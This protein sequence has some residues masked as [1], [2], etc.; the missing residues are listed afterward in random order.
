MHTRRL[1]GNQS[2]SF[3]KRKRS[4]S[5]VFCGIFIISFFLIIFG[6]SKLTYL[7]STQISVI[8]VE[9]ASQDII[10][11]VRAAAEE[12]IKGDYLWMFSK[13]NSFLYPKDQIENKVLVASP[14]ID[15]VSVKRNKLDSI[16][17][18]VIEKKPAA[19][20]CVT[21]P[22]FV[23]GKLIF[24]EDEECA[25]IDE[26]GLIFKSAP[27]ISGTVYNRYYIPDFAGTAS[28]SQAYFG[29]LATSTKEFQN[30]QDLYDGLRKNNI[31]VQAI[32]FKD[33]G[34]YEAYVNN[35]HVQGSVDTGTAVIYFNN[36]RP[37]SVELDNL[38]LFWGRAMEDAKTHNK[39]PAFEY[40]DVRY[41]PNVFFRNIK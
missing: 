9:G 25:M 28:T 35:P 30:L 6:I 34:E 24:G 38:V 37:L 1:V 16:V 19:M 36:A 15:T 7:S 29:V 27:S 22:D 39:L 26:T 8:E 17:I 18:S 32:L 23:A 3:A 13:S 33:K 11:T 10:P 20:V 14:R 12:S 41:S 5:L 21:L 31:E 40:I 2:E 4:R